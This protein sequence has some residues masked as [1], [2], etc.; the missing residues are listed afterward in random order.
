MLNYCCTLKNKLTSIIWKMEK[1]SSDFV[2]APKRNFTRKSKLS[3]SETMKFILG[4]GGK[5][6]GK[7]LMDFYDF[8]ANMVS[9][10]AVVQRRTKIKP[11]AFEYL[12]HSFN[13]EFSPT[14]F[15]YGY[16]LYAVD[17]S[18]VHYPVN[19]CDE[20]NY[21]CTNEN[22]KGYN[23]MHLNTLYGLLNQYYLDAVVQN[24]SEMNENRAMIHM[25]RKIK[26]DAIIVADRNYESYNNMA[27]LKH[28]GLKYIIRIKDTVAIA[29]RLPLTE[30]QGT[31]I[32]VDILLTRRQTKE[33]KANPLKYRSLLSNVTFDFLPLQSKEVY[34]IHF[35]VVKMKV[36]EGKFEILVTNLS[37]EEFTSEQLKQV[38]RLRW[39]IETSFR[40]LKYN[41]GL[42]AFHSKKKD[43]VIQEIFARL[44]MYNF[45]MLIT[46]N[47]LMG[48]KCRKHSS[49]VNYAVAVHVCICFFCS[50]RISPDDVEKIIARNRISVRPDRHAKR[51][52]AYH[53]TV[54][55]NYRF[56]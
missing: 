35:K 34:P 51:H 19:P 53:S 45:S 47:I 46:K 21:V 29:K 20:S 15:F 56:S 28:Q 39:E 8:H 36:K 38:Y 50:A 14:R 12:F 52:T 4:M 37:R 9:V 40:E 22:A 41:V 5:T 16:R 25:S 31:D 54:C 27:H 11:Y 24:Y 13:K 18:D 2:V 32:D 48:T 30:N 7:E 6:L 44:T 42:N 49:K 10:S 23:L 43:C 3:L 55:F 17:G 26:H 1:N 33:V